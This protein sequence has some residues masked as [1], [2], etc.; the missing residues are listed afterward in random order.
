MH[1]YTHK[2]M[3]TGVNIMACGHKQGLLEMETA[4]EVSSCQMI[5]ELG[6]YKIKTYWLAHLM[7]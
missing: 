5:C 3:H 1:I 7:L 6:S 4:P 2:C